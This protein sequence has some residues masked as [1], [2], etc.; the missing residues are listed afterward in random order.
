METLEERLKRIEYHQ[1]LICKMIGSHHYPVFDLIIR[2]KLTKAESEELFQICLDLTEKYEKQKE[3]GLLHFKS[4]LSDFK[5][6]L[7]NKLGVE[8]TVHAF[9][10]QNMYKPLMES[11][12]KI[13]EEEKEGNRRK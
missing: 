1:E 5:R 10:L 2:T 9:Y 8:E 11:F 12:I 13:I 6:L 7:N 3:E 4:L